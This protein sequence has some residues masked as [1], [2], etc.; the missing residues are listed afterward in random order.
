[1]SSQS[2]GLGA[3]LVMTISAVATLFALISCR[4]AASPTVVSLEIAQ[5]KTASSEAIDEASCLVLRCSSMEVQ[6]NAIVVG[7]SK[8]KSVKATTLLFLP[9]LDNGSTEEYV[10][11]AAAP[12]TGKECE[13][14]LAQAR[15]FAVNTASAEAVAGQHGIPFADWQAGAMSSS[16]KFPC[17]E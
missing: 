5:D 6:G 17:C 9:S 4:A 13:Y 10:T 1:M 7:T 3:R 16:E 11:V 8:S 2:S 15:F 14:D 12:V